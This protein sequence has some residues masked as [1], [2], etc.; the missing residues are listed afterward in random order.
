MQKTQGGEKLFVFT[1]LFI[2]IIISPL[3]FIFVD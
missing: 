2:V 3:V 1:V